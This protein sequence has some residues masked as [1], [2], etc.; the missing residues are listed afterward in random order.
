MIF[1]ST[2][3]YVFSLSSAA[4]T[5]MQLLDYF[6]HESVTP[7]LPAQHCLAIKFKI[8]IK[9]LLFVCK[10]FNNLT[11]QTCS[12]PIPLSRSYDLNLLTEP[13]T[14]LKKQAFAV[15]GPKL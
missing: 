3:I 10:A 12:A 8:Y 7:I 11:L 1:L 4:D 2:M 6:W 5:K 9:I 15:A 13:R 14:H